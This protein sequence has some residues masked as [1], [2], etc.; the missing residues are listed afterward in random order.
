MNLLIQYVIV[1][2]TLS[3]ET[4]A[5]SS[6]ATMLASPGGCTEEERL[7]AADIAIVDG[8]HLCLLPSSFGH[9]IKKKQHARSGNINHIDSSEDVT[10]ITVPALPLSS[11]RDI[12]SGWEFISSSGEEVESCDGT[13]K[14]ENEEGGSSSDRDSVPLPTEMI[15]LRAS[16]VFN[17]P[18][19]FIRSVDLIKNN[20]SS[21]LP[22]RVAV[23]CSSDV[24]MEETSRIVTGDGDGVQCLNVCLPS[25]DIV[26]SHDYSDGACRVY[27]GEHY[28]IE[29]REML[30]G[31]ERTSKTS[32]SVEIH[33]AGSCLVADI[34]GIAGHEQALVLPRIDESLLKDILWEA[35]D[36]KDDKSAKQK[37]HLLQ[38]MLRSSIITDGSGM[39]VSSHMKEEIAQ[40]NTGGNKTF[41][42]QPLEMHEEKTMEADA[43]KSATDEN[44]TSEA[45]TQEES[46]VHSPGEGDNISSNTTNGI[47]NH[48]ADATNVE[49]SNATKED[50]AWLNA[51]ARTVEHRL[52][53]EVEESEQVQRSIQAR[54]ELVEQGRRT[55]HAATRPNHSTNNWNDPEIIRL[56]YGTR[57]R[58]S[59]VGCTGITVVL[60]LELDVMMP[61]RVGIRDTMNGDATECNGLHDFHI[62]CTKVASSNTTPRKLRTASGVVPSLQSG[63]C[64]TMLV[65]VVLSDLEMDMQQY[66]DSSTFD[67][68]IQG[69]WLDALSKTQ[70][71]DI[72]NPLQHPTRR[73]AVLCLLRLPVDIILLAP[74][75]S[76][77]PK[78]GHW[79]QHEI[80][81]TSDYSGIKCPE[82]STIVEYRQPCTLTIDASDQMHFT[83]DATMWKDLV[84]N[85][86]ARIGGNSFVDLYCRKDDPRLRL[87]VYGSNPEERAAAVSLV[88]RSL[89]ES[90]KL[91]MDDTNET[92]N[93]KAL[94][95]SLKMEADALQRHRAV[96]KVIRP[97]MLAEAATLQSNTDGIASTIKR[98]W[99]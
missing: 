3:W 79:I 76:S 65:S 59:S 1:T 44:G 75:L 74:P 34:L 87:V 92:Q 63:D 7:V 15:R 43:M 91:V 36:E 25:S 66:S 48:N 9:C 77:T 22:T 73:G 40:I 19:R 70:S 54:S 28:N 85:L 29:D 51:I 17:A 62:S 84:S 23:S 68:S 11:M 69:L 83:H 10:Q 64:I 82:P 16:D 99:A 5:T 41:E 37:K 14:E 21:G 6:Q 53:R 27:G 35:G 60:D 89:P 86:N 96:S 55:L 47:A 94:L 2:H 90:A 46:S 71:T 80:D 4:N 72:L 67:M 97:E 32:I 39:L 38:T 78:S 52:G 95:T 58:T 45:L 26:A 49:E 56:R 12:V 13:L 8:T 33:G 30:D 81:F 18:Y 50:P 61:S 24:M 42:L 88:L 98:G 57:P 31:D 93:V 20:R